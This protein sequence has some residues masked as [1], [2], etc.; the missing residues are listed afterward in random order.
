MAT[1]RTNNF[2]TLRGW[3]GSLSLQKRENK[4]Q[5]PL[6]SR[7]GGGGM[8]KA[9]VAGPLSVCGFPYAPSRKTI[10]KEFERPKVLSGKPI[11]KSLL[12]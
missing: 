12:I 11:V 8:L 1:L 3:W 5:W 10:F 4:H 6:S 7:S 9:L 2:K